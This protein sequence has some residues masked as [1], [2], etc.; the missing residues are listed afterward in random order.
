MAPTLTEDLKRRMTKGEISFVEE[1]PELAPI[2][3]YDRRGQDK[4]A[5]CLV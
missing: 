3:R 4:I 1:I 2:I 5:V